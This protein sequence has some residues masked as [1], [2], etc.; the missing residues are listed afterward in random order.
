MKKEIIATTATPPATD[1]P[2]MVPVPTPES[3][4]EFGGAKD[5][6]VLDAVDAETVT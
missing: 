1:K 3:E 6:D 5:D 4:L 2:I